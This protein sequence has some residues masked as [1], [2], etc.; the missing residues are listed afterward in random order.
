[1]RSTLAIQVESESLVR[2]GAELAVAGCFRDQRPLRGGAGVADW[3][4]CGWLSALV[5]ATRMR[6]EWGEATLLPTHARLGAPRLLLVGLGSRPRFGSDAHRR[7]VQAAI[8]R[9]LDLGAGT[10]ALDLP[11]PGPDG[12]AEQ[13][14]NGLVEGACAALDS[15]SARLLVRQIAPPGQAARLRAALEHAVNAIPRGT[16]SI[17]MIRSPAASP[18]APSQKPGNG[19][20]GQKPAKD[21]RAEAP[22][23]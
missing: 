4:L 19:P 20:P 22:L 1:V 11:P 2:V 8:D 14:A 21:G 9:V 18:G 23:G 12:S 6:G 3:R 16:T 10:V 7:A 15:R 13:L 17:R 5:A